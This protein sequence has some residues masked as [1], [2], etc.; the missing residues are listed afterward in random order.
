MTGRLRHALHR[1]RRPLRYALLDRLL[2]EQPANRTQALRRREEDLRR[3]VQFAVANTGYY[4]GRFAEAGIDPAGS[5]SLADLPLLRKD[6]VRRHLD[7]MRAHTAGPDAAIG[8]TGGSTGTPLAFWYDGFKHELMRAGMCRS[9]MGSGWRPGQKIMNFWGARQDTVAGGVFG[10]GWEDF[11]AA[12]R[13]VSAYEYTAA[14][15][16]AWAAAIRDYRPV[17]LHGYASVLAE[18]ARHVLARGIAMPKGLLGVYPTAEVL[19]DSQREAMER[20]FGCKVFNQ[21]GSREIPNIACEC[22][23]GNMHV[24]SDMVYL[25]SLPEG[26]EDRLIVTSLTNRLMPFIRYDIGDSGRLLDG[27][28]GCGWPF[29]LMEMGMCRQN[30]LIR[31]RDGRTF[32]PSYFNRLLYGLTQVEQYQFVQEAPQR[33]VLNVVS[34]EPL[35]AS[36][37]GSIRDH[38][39]RDLGPEVDFQLNRVAEIP[40]TASGKHRFVISRCDSTAR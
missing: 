14:Q 32:H 33:I 34:A 1:L 31:T 20:A 39:R 38:I 40:R 30:D 5:W 16:D 15:L 18:L 4:A 12:E 21:Y 28:C 36:I 29:P 37:P 11:I 9:Y 19:D 17:L 2:H 25:E 13:T 27:E 6:D 26:G 7:A 23:H 22:R 24:F 8:H 10:T 3:I 35:D